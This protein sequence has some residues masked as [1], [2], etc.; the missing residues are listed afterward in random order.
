MRAIFVN[1]SHPDTPHVSGMRVPRFAEAMARRGHQIVLI[2]K[3]LQDNDLA[4]PPEQVKEEL[5]NHDWNEPYHI[6]CKP[7]YDSWLDHVRSNHIPAPLRKAVV[8]WYLLKRYGVFSDWV[9]GSKP[10]WDILVED[11]KP[12]VTWGSFG[13]VD[14]FSLARNLASRAGV[15]WVMDIKDTW[16][17]CV[18]KPLQRI[19]A[20]RFDDAAA[21]TVN[22]RFQAERSAIWFGKSAEILY[23]G[24]PSHLFDDARLTESMGEFRI[25]LVGSTYGEERLKPFIETIQKWLAR[26]LPDERSLITFGY[27]GGDSA[28]VK[29]LS[30]QMAGLC[31]MEVHNYLPISELFKACKASAVNCYLWLPTVFH[32]KLMELLCCRRPVITFPGEYSE[33]VEIA[34]QVGG[35]LY[36]CKDAISVCNV[37]DELWRHRLENRKCC[38]PKPLQAFTWDSQATTLEKALRQVIAGKEG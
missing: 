37:L 29:R 13:N 21:L 22:S 26:R 17:E 25:T 16:E 11:F 32:H 3:T 10:Y 38:D 30:S 7:V 35:E 5:L 23:S 27:A 36:I 34:Q 14:V 6:A 1:Y 19:L 8:A 24:V 28:L 15:R 12:E 4:K 33:A 20:R 2:T 9:E 31:R 18:P